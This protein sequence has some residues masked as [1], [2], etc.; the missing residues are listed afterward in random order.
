MMEELFLK[1]EYSVRNFPDHVRDN[2]R[3]RLNFLLLDL[4]RVLFI[5]N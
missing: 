2:H 4:L 5:S 1:R 3:L